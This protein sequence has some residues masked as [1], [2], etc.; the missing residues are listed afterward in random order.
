MSDQIL[1]MGTEMFPDTWAISDQLAWLIFQEH[2]VS[3]KCSV[4][5][6]RMLDEAM[7]YGHIG[8]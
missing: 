7:E 6:L 4:T 8:H 1:V 2:F 5:E 3:P